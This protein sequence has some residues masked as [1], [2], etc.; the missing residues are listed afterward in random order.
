MPI[1]ISSVLDVL[2]VLAARDI[3]SSEAF[4]DQRIDT[5][6]RT[7]PSSREGTLPKYV[8]RLHRQHAAKG[9]VL[10]IEYIDDLAPVLARMAAKR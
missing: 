9:E 7:M 3:S 6:L 8:G 5:L 4:G 10:V 1:A 2:D